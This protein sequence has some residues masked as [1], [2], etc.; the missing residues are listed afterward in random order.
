MLQT[1]CEELKDT[2][3]EKE[4]TILETIREKRKKRK[5]LFK[6]TIRE[7]EE[8]A[9]QS[10]ENRFKR[11]RDNIIQSIQRITSQFA[12]TIREKEA[13]EDVIQSSSDRIEELERRIVDA[14]K[15][16]NGGDLKSTP[17]HGRW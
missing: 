4:N 2:I 1:K 10:S 5:I 13:K 11:E 7:M 16:S 6:R 15:G 9:L 17:I 14:E 3:R 8:N 12:D